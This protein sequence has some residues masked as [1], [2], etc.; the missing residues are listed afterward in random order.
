MISKF[1]S[2][3]AV[4]A[5]IY[6]DLNLQKSIRDQD[7]IEW[8]GEALEYMSI[9]AFYVKKRIELDI[10]N[11]KAKL[12]C[13]FVSVIAVEYGGIGLTASNSPRLATLD[14]EEV[15]FIS[16]SQDTYQV[17]YPF[18]ITDTTQNGKIRVYYNAFPVDEEG[19]PLVPDIIEYKE[20]CLKYVHYKISYAAF[21]ADQTPLQKYDY[22]KREW[23]IALNAAVAIG[24]MPDPDV[25]IGIAQ[26]WNRLIP[27]FLEHKQM[28]DTATDPQYNRIP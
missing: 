23:Q 3:K 16:A 18:I 19:Y 21:V 15:K 14:Q 25:A 2:S 1:T 17:R 27:N 4:V 5:K 6:T 22:V 28:F 26:R 13:D 10:K 9:N 11:Y 12:P 8:I 7:L 20:A 24:A